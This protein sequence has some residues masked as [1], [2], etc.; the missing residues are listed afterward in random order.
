V[1]GPV[2]AGRIYE[3]DLDIL[4]AHENAGLRLWLGDG[5][6]SWTAFATDIPNS[7]TYTGTAIADV[8][9][10]GNMDLVASGNSLG[11]TVLTGD[12][13]TSWSDNSSGL[14]NSDT[15]H[16]LN[17][18]DVDNDGNLDIVTGRWKDGRL[19]TVVTGRPYSGYGAVAI[20]PDGAIQSS[21]K[22][23]HSYLPLLRKMVVF[24]QT[25]KA[26]VPNAETIEMF[27]FMAHGYHHEFPDD[28]MRLVAPPLMLAFLGL[29][30]GFIYYLVFGAAYWVQVFGGTFIGYLA[31][32]WIHYY[33]HHFRPTS[34]VGK[35][36]RQYHLQHHFDP[37]YDRFGISNPLWDVIFRTYRGV[38]K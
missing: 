19:G 21:P 22:P 17:I 27:A 2:E 20:L 16:G 26:P 29:I 37:N 36:L 13:G 15:Y 3:D 25:G 35:W 6:T 33:T 32:D 5:G 7:G 14:P 8:D 9:K 30:V 23:K 38:G 34:G 11:I 12:G 31:Y 1:A 10:D 4:A 24:F 28:K 18:S